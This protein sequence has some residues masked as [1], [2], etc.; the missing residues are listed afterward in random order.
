MAAQNDTLDG[1]KDPD[2]G[3]HAV[4]AVILWALLLVLASLTL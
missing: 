3:L 1:R 4:T 2:I